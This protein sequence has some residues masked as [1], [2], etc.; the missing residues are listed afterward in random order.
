M[1]LSVLLQALPLVPALMLVVVLGY[2]AVRHQRLFL[3]LFMLLTAFEST[4]DFAPSLVVTLSGF[5][6]YPEDLVT[7]VGAGA[8]LAR[9]G[10]WRLRPVTRAAML[11][12]TVLAGLGV[13]TWI[14]T[15]GLKLGVNFWRPQLLMVALL[16]YTTTRPRAWSWNDLRVI[17]VASAIVVALASVVG[18]T[19]HGF[20]SSSSSIVVDGGIEGGR[21]VSASGSLLML[22]GLWITVSSAGKWSARRV[23]VVLLLGSMVLLT[24]NR[25]VWVAAILGVVVWWLVPRIRFRGASGG[26]SGIS[27]T[28]LVFFVAAATALV[29]G[30]LASLG[31]SA[32]NDDTWL[33]R[34]AR[35]TDSMAVPRSW[36]EWLVGSAFGPTPAATPTL[37]LT[38]A[39]SLYVDAI[40]MT[41]FI[42]L[43]AVLVLV[44]AVGRAQVAPSIG[45]LGLIVCV[46]FLSFGVSYQLPAW[47]WMAVGIL[48]AGTRAEQPDGSGHKTP[49]TT[50]G[51]TAPATPGDR[52]VDRT[53]L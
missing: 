42:E 3:A 51:L 39:H 22:I 24:Q 11:V 31:Q 12:V 18:I 20:G 38:S 41:G 29:G 4:R 35:W 28:L 44:I 27:R 13:I 15:Y 48:L 21:P 8:A 14:S 34:V 17:I 47:A 30:S 6:V 32:S 40:E 16:L 33:W 25:S 50:R 43:A 5:S 10:Q 19:M 1:I 49:D 2:I 26:L 45:P 37:F 7:V 52:V 46:S 23:L 9:I 53:R 36:V